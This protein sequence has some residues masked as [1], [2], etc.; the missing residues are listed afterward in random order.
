MMQYATT[1]R[2][3]P[4]KLQHFS[5]ISCRRTARKQPG[6][7]RRKVRFVTTDAFGLTGTTAPPGRVPGPTGADRAHQSRQRTCQ[8]G[9][10]GSWL[11]RIAPSLAKE[12]RDRGLR[13][14]TE[15]WRPMRISAQACGCCG[16]SPVRLRDSGGSGR[17]VAPQDG[18]NANVKPDVRYPIPHSVLCR[19]LKSRLR[20]NKTAILFRVRLCCPFRH[21]RTMGDPYSGA[22]FIGGVSVWLGIVGPQP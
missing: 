21:A 4:S 6:S 9:D 3:S 15:R 18:E 1:S 14:A 12:R 7:R 5:V 8:G 10:A 19:T 11:V 20:V 13:A 16:G 22:T 2:R 17:V